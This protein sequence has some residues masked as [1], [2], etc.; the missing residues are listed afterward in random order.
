MPTEINFVAIAPDGSPG[1]ALA[2]WHEFR[3]AICIVVE[4][5]ADVALSAALFDCAASGRVLLRG[6]K[7]IPRRARHVFWF[8]DT[9]GT[10]FTAG[11]PADRAVGVDR[12][13]AIAT[14][15]P[16]VTLRYLERSRSFMKS[17]HRRSGVGLA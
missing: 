2:L 5:A 11:L 15:R 9:L 6:E 3:T 13:A 8:E 14:T 12:I 17:S 1:T 4:N 10:P 16:D 7:V